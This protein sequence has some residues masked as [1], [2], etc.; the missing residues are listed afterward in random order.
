[1]QRAY[2]RTVHFIVKARQ[3]AIEH[4]GNIMNHYFNLLSRTE[5]AATAVCASLLSVFTVGA[6]I[7]LFSSAIPDAVSSELVAFDVAVVTTS[8]NI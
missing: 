1:L 3:K 6:V 7:M 4:K 5:S 8:N 2:F